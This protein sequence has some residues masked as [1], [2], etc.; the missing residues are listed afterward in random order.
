[1]RRVSIC[2][3]SSEGTNGGFLTWNGVPASTAPGRP[4][5][6]Y[7]VMP[8]LPFGGGLAGALEG[9]AESE[10]ASIITP[11]AVE[12]QSSSAEAQAA[13][14]SAKNGAT[15]YRSG[16]LG[17]SMAGESQYWSLQ[18]PLSPGY[19]EQM[20]MPSVSPDFVMTGTLS[21]GASVITNEAPG[22]GSNAGGGIQVVTSIGG[23]ASLTIYMPPF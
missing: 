15:L 7:G 22:L 9:L 1:M 6:I 19:A 4:Q 14:Q 2:A 17:T 3:E 21:P 11:Y 18:N 20:G 5:L 10:A 16:Q 13:L 23:V 12:V 8:G